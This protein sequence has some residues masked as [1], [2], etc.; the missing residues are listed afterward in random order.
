MQLDPSAHTSV[1]I[2]M[3]LVPYQS[4]I[5]AEFLQKG[6]HLQSGWLRQV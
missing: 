1:D 3:H 4:D 5:A 6:G 2:Y